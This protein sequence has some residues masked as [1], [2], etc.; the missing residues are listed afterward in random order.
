MPKVCMILN[1]RH[2]AVTKVCGYT[3]RDSRGGCN[4]VLADLIIM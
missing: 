3:V 4:N 2:P 1:A